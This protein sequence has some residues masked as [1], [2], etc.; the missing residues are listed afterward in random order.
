MSRR[1][2]TPEARQARQERFAALRHQ[3][4]A[5]ERTVSVE[6][7]IAFGAQFDTAYSEH[8]LLM[9]MAQMPDATDVAGFARWRER[10]RQVRKGEKGLVIFA[11]I[12][13][14]S[15]EPADADDGAARHFKATYVFDISQ[16]DPIEAPVAVTP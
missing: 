2:L 5:L 6:A 11:S 13:E 10:G 3:V 12:P 14:R 7:L 16:T 4:S 15:E 8:N 9:I 1:S